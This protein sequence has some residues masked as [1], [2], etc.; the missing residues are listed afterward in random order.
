MKSEPVPVYPGDLLDEPREAPDN[1]DMGCDAAVE[2]ANF[3]HEI[4]MEDIHKAMK[5]DIACKDQPF[6]DIAHHLGH[7]IH[8]L[9]T[10]LEAAA[11][12]WLDGIGKYHY[13]SKPNVMLFLLKRIANGK[14]AKLLESMGRDD[15]RD[16]VW[17][18]AVDNM[19]RKW[20]DKHLLK[21]KAA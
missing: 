11:E 21:R 5:K 20:A 19:G 8:K 16:R 2:E 7:E 10:T 9:L 13:G 1:L 6:P 3:A 17:N 4:D 12:S 18:N 14:T 15:Y